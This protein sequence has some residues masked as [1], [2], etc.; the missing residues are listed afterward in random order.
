[1][2]LAEKAAAA[3]AGDGGDVDDPT[4]A[5][6]HH[7]GSEQSA[8]DERAAEVRPERLVPLVATELDERAARRVARGIDEERHRAEL[9]YERA[10]G[11]PVGRVEDVGGRGR[12]R[13]LDL[14]HCV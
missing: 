1:R 5:S 2:R 7:P 13:A 10:Q 9:R 11:F 8:G 6:F 12:A 4:V 14:R 3:L